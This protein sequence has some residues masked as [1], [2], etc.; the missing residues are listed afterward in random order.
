MKNKLLLHTCCAPCFSGVLPQI[1]DDFEVTSY[2]FNPNIYPIEEYKKRLDNLVRY[3]KI[4]KTHVIINENYEEDN[5]CW[6]KLTSR[7][8]AE[9]EG[10]ARCAKCIEYR[11]L[12]TA[13][14]AYNN[15]YEY[16]ATTLSV[17]PHKD[18]LLV[19]RLGAKIESEFPEIKFLA[20]D[21][22]KKDGY[23]KSIDLCEKYNIYRQKYCGCVYSA[24]NF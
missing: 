14:Y 17:S 1:Q 19:N 20:A 11:L 3:A 6:N 23:K 10:G 24:K 2:W 9:P 12:E 4:T 18:A 22:K 15:G 16:F 7:Y 13:R 8:S 5:F 21:F